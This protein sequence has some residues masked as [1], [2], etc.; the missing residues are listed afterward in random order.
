MKIAHP[1]PE[2]IGVTGDSAGLLLAFE[3][4]HVSHAQSSEF[5]SCREPGRTSAYD[6]HATIEQLHGVTPQPV[7]LHSSA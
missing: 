5:D 7:R 1:K 6:D 3:Q 2:V 4:R